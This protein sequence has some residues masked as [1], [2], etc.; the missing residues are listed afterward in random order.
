MFRDIQEAYA[1]LGNRQRRLQYE[2]RHRRAQPSR[3]YR[4][5]PQ[6]PQRSPEPLIPE[7]RPE[8][9]DLGE[10]SPIRSFQT[11]SPSF[12]EISD[13]LWHN[14]S[15]LGRQQSGRVEQLTME[16][17][18]TIE[19]A[20]QGGLAEVMVP[21]RAVCRTCQGT[22]AVGVYE[23]QRCAGQGAITGEVPVSV[24]FPPGIGTDHAVVIPLD[25]F[26]IRNLQ[27]TV[28]FRPSSENHS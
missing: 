27:L 22:G 19:Q 17:P 23:C 12:D 20:E 1:V 6:K 2:L 7:Q 8:P 16:V 5:Q 10:I 15:S 9:V 25:R 18:L 24:S 14:F 4:T 28:L 11:F 26:G 21:A 13:W 3:P